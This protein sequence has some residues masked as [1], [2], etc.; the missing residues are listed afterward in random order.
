MIPREPLERREAIDLVL[1][2][3]ALFVGMLIAVAAIMSGSP[4]P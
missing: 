2:L 3:V 1:V 4:R